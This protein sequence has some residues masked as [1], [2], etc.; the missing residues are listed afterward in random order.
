MARIKMGRL[1]SD[2][3]KIVEKDTSIDNLRIPPTAVSLVL[4][5]VYLLLSL[6]I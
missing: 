1:D 5:I 6:L 3:I 4:L 2:V